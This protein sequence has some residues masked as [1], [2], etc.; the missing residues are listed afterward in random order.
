MT[1]TTTTAAMKKRYQPERKDLQDWTQCTV[2]VTDE[3]RVGWYID[4]LIDHD[5]FVR[6]GNTDPDDNGHGS[7]STEGTKQRRWWASKF[8]RSDQ[9]GSIV[10]TD[11]SIYYAFKC[12][13]AQEGDAV[14]GIKQCVH[15]ERRSTKRRHVP[16]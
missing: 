9:V 12:A 11:W 3:P 14:G 8:Y 7:L 2:L 6:I 15:A 1:T 10:C 16:R 13:A 4:V 5:T